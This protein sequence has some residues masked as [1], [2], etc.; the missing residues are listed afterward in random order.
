MAFS[1]AVSSMEIDIGVE[2][3]EDYRRKGLAAILAGRM[4]EHIAAIGKSRCGLAQL[5]IKAP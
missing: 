5:R 3:H 1:A 2:T 4:C